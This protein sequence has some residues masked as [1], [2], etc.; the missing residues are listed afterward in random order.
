MEGRGR[1]GGEGWMRKRME[2]EKGFRADGRENGWRTVSEN[3]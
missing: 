3:G 1:T 2:K